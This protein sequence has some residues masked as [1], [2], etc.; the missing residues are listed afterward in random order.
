MQEVANQKPGQRRGVSMSTY[1]LER[2]LDDLR[3]M[4]DDLRMGNDPRLMRV[5]DQVELAYCLGEHI[6]RHLCTEEIK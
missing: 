2:Y 4:V 3:V 6:Y 5:A 1:T